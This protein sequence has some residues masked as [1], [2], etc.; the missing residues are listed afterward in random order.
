M[1]QILFMY[2]GELELTLDEKKDSISGS[3]AIT[4]PPGI[5]HGF[6]FMPGAE[7]VVLSIADPLLAYQ[8]NQVSPGYFGDILDHPQVMNFSQKNVLLTQLVQ[9]LSLIKGESERTDAGY[10][11][12][13]EWLIQMVLM[14]LKRLY[15][16]KHHEERHSAT[17][18]TS[19]GSQLLSRFR[20]L[21]ETH[22]RQH[23]KVS[24]YSDALNT[25]V[26]SLNR[27]CHENLSVTAKAIIQDRVMIEAKRRLIYTQEPLDQMAYTLGFKDPAY[28]SRM[29]K[30]IEQVSPSDYRKQKK[31]HPNTI[32]L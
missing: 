3:Y 2:N 20:K 15:E 25:S 9:Y 12:M 21:L 7:G 1:F 22:Y 24:Q 6:R 4:I 10:Q 27:L 26:S 16:Q 28:F 29:F 30:K 23:W 19:T 31:Q 11:L 14:T 5:V 18:H 32:Q 13:Q 17:S 8:K